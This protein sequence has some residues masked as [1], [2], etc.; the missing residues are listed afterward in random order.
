M[1]L[2]LAALAAVLPAGAHVISMSSS[3]LRVEGTRAH[4]ELRMPLYEMQHVTSPESTLFANIRFTSGGAAPRIASRRCAEDR[5]DAS[6]K[7]TAELEWAN[8]VESVEV[9]CTFHTVTVA[10]HVHLLRATLEDKTDQAVFDFSNPK[11]LIRFR[12]PSDFELFVTAWGSGFARP[13]AGGATILF[14]ACLAIAARSRW[15]LLLM[16]GM[17][18][19]GQVSAAVIVPAT[20]WNPAPRFVEAAMALTVAYLAVEI[21]TLPDA[22]KR[23]LVAGVL[24]SFHGLALAIYLVST[25]YGPAA[26]LSGMA[27]A[28][29]LVLAVFAAVAWRIARSLA[30]VAPMVTKFTAS[31]FLITGMIWFFY[32]LRM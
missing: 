4:W 15:E 7:C 5:Q 29:V 3:D 21:L 20:T 13:F 17:F 2:W 31:F 23:W 32:R 18:L 27:F 8:P 12:P 19:A 24:G 1:R 30:A 28:E 26:A 25:G 11:A 6:Y 10:N 16:G 22:G 14:L 9:V